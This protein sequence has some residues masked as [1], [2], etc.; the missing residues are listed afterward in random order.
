M[1][2]QTPAASDSPV[3]GDGKTDLET[4]N[5]KLARLTTN[6]ESLASPFDDSDD[7]E[8][9]SEID[10]TQYTEEEI[11]YVGSPTSISRCH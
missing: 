1:H 9:D 4:V 3:E 8:S 2:E 5:D 10:F 6:T 7:E 11:G